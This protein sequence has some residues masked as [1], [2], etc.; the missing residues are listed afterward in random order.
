MKDLQLSIYDTLGYVIPSFILIFGAFE[1]LNLY[2]P[3][4][5]RIAFMASFSATQWI[6]LVIISYF[7]GHCLH[8]ISN[9]TLD[10]F[11]GYPTKGYFEKQFKESFDE[12][13]VSELVKKLS[14][15]TGSKDIKNNISFLKSSYWLCYTYVVNNSSNALSP[16]FLSLTGFYRG[17]S[18]SFTLLS[19]S[20][21]VR[22]VFFGEVFKFVHLF[23]C[24]LFLLLFIKR[25]FRFSNYLSNSVYSEFLV[26]SKGK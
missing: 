15:I 11:L 12:Y 19:V 7:I 6:I 20:A 18:I 4:G 24:I 16:I 26:L 8:A 17:L 13:A 25:T 2:H 23:A 1:I 22:I 21:L 14:V 3:F 9:L 5:G 10:K